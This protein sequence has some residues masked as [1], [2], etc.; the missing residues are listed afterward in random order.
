[1][2]IEAGDAWNVQHRAEQPLP[3]A[4]RNFAELLQELRVV[5]TGVQI[6]FGFL[7][8][9][10]F[11]GRF[12][13]FDTLQRTLHTV[14]LVSAAATSALIVAPVAA[15]RILF[16]RNRKREIVR[17]G[18]RLA[19]VG[20]GL[21]ATTLCAGLM[22]AV[23]VTIGRVPAVAVAGALIL[24]IVALWVVLPLRMRADKRAD[25]ILEDPNPP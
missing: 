14:T 2:A 10:S 19:L 22:L 3:R 6:L 8:T 21:L 5:F 25:P 13:E 15:H 4:D 16:R 1:V 7:L 20:L 18:H 24:T 23:D 12:A 9:L 17:V 11:S